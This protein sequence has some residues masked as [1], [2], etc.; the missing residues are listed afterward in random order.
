M[1]IVANWLKFFVDVSGKGDP[2]EPFKIIYSE[3]DGTSAKSDPTEY[4]VPG[5]RSL[6]LS[7][8]TD[9]IPAFRK[10]EN[11]KW[12][13]P[14]TA[15]RQLD[16]GQFDGFRAY[17]RD[18]G[19]WLLKP[20]GNFADDKV[21]S[22]IGIEFT[23]GTDLADLAWELL[24]EPKKAFLSLRLAVFRLVA[25]PRELQPRPRGRFPI[26]V[27]I[28]AS[29]GVRDQQ[30]KLDVSSEIRAIK[31]SLERPWW[32]L[33]AERRFSVTALRNA[34]VAKLR[35][36]LL[37][38]NKPP[39]IVHFT[40]HGA[41]GGGFTFNQHDEKVASE[42]PGAATAP[43]EILAEG[44]AN[45]LGKSATQL[46]VLSFCESGRSSRK[47]YQGVAQSIAE[48]GVPFVVG[49]QAEVKEKT[50]LKFCEGF[51]RALAQNG[52]VFAALVQGRNEISTGGPEVEHEFA[53][54]ALYSFGNGGV[55]TVS[56]FTNSLRCSQ[57]AWELLLKLMKFLHNHI[58]KLVA[59]IAVS[60][61]SGLMIHHLTTPKEPGLKQLPNESPNLAQSDPPV[62]GLVGTLANGDLP[63]KIQVPIA[64]DINDNRYPIAKEGLE[65]LKSDS[66]LNSD[67]KLKIHQHSDQLGYLIDAENAFLRADTLSV[68]DAL[69]NLKDRLPQTGRNKIEEAIEQ[70]Q[71]VLNDFVRNHLSAKDKI[72]DG[73][74]S[75]AQELQRQMPRH[76]IPESWRNLLKGEEFWQEISQPDFDTWRQDLQSIA[77][78]VAIEDL[79]KVF[80]LSIVP[81]R[82]N[83]TD[84]GE[85]RSW[86]VAFE[87]GSTEISLVQRLYLVGIVR[88]ILASPIAVDTELTIQL[89]ANDLDALDLAQSRA[90]VLA[91]E[92]ISAGL[93]S[94]QFSISTVQSERPFDHKTFDLVSDQAALLRLRPK[95]VPDIR[96]E[97]SS[98]EI[99]DEEENGIELLVDWLVRNP[100]RRIVLEGHADRRGTEEFNQDLSEKRARNV[101]DRVSLKLEKL[102]LPTDRIEVQGY[103]EMQAI[104]GTSGRLS[105]DRRVTAIIL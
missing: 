39:D 52:D 14:H 13:E 25:P 104:S 38:T 30:Q 16:P 18:Q 60:V 29:S 34:T 7:D 1:G 57:R 82:L 87:S 31:K 91:L 77:P 3:M 56:H 6:G 42:R 94:A 98:T 59:A 37:A 100:A 4:N 17:G 15:P 46:V 54:P 101:A 8:S 28:V 67:Q 45:T 65:I 53:A 21:T 102:G 24:A 85:P 19:R 26:R 88:N 103:G 11:S 73:D 48:A 99:G 22:P 50:C 55:G 35:K 44:L 32:K 49:M 41:N 80:D 95:G 89:I 79:S 86:R 58:G 72:S 20:T 74:L 69:S 81:T 75:G 23:P 47:D 78:K 63:D 62:P 68:F 10:A 40:G 97:T 76:S 27:L 9:P 71:R 84:T 96:F 5:D 70:K 61:I 12:P 92:L 33:W 93:N 2:E 43:H 66:S 105:L 64:K 83:D 90:D 36:Q 51:Y